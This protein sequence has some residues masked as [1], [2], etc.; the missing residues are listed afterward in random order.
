MIHRL[1]L[2]GLL[3][4]LAGCGVKGPLEMPDTAAGTPEAAALPQNDDLSGGAQPSQDLDDDEA[5][6]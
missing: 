1:I 6:P 2:G 4:L 3:V 5:L